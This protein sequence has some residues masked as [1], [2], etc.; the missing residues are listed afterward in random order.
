MMVLPRPC[1][2]QGWWL[3]LVALVDFWISVAL[4]LVGVSRCWFS[5][6]VS[7]GLCVPSLLVTWPG[8]RSCCLLLA[9]LCLDLS[10]WGPPWLDDFP[11]LGSS[12]SASQTA[13]GGPTLTWIVMVL[14][15]L[16]ASVDAHWRS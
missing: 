10:L 5:Q 14:V 11:H 7:P 4:P 1:I 3:Q 2:Q 15:D 12:Y 13:P 6:R 8:D 9:G 16:G